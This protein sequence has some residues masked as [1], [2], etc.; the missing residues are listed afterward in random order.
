MHDAAVTGTTQVPSLPR[1]VVARDRLLRRLDEIT[2]HAVT[3]VVAPRGTGKTVL[4]A[5]WC[6]RRSGRT[7]WANLPPDAKSGVLDD[8]AAHAAEGATDLVVVLDD[9]NEPASAS[10]AVDAAQRLAAASDRVHVVLVGCC[11]PPELVPMRMAGRAWQLPEDELYL[12]AAEVAGVVAA[13]SGREVPDD[14][15]DELAGH[16]D[17][18]MA[19]AVLV[20][21]AAPRR[22]RTPSA[23]Y[24]ASTGSIDAYVTSVLLAGLPAD[25][26]DFVVATAAVDDLDPRLCGVLTA[27]EH[28]ERQLAV[29]RSIGFPIV[30][31]RTD[32]G[33]YLRPLRDSLERIAR[34]DDAAAH[35]DRLRRAAEWYR[36]W[37]RPL[38]AAGCLVRLGEWYAAERLIN[39]HLPQLLAR[40]EISRLAELVRDAPPEMLREQAVLALAGAWVLRMDGRV[41][42]SNELI[43]IYTPYYSERAS[44][45]ADL[46][47]SSTASWVADMEPLVE[48]AERAVEACD[49]LGPDAFT[50][51]KEWHGDTSTSEFRARARAAA[52]LACAYGGM[53]A[54]GERHLEPI[55]AEAAMNLPQFQLVH[56]HGVTATFH[57]LSGR[58]A[59]ALVE[60]HRATT[61]AAQSDL[62]EHRLTADAAYALGEALRLQLRHQD[63]AAA[64]ERARRLAATNGR[65]NLIATVVASQ[66]H[67]AVDAGRPDVA[68]ATIAD[69]RRDHPVR[70]PATVGGLIAAAEARSLNASGRFGEAL[71]LLDRGPVTSPVASMRVAALLGL[72]DVA[73]AQ[74]TVRQWPGGQTHDAV[75]RRAVAAAVICERTG[76]RRGAGL[77]QT[78]L[79]TADE[80]GLGQPFAEHGAAVAR[81]LRPRVVGD[82]EFARALQ[83]W[84]ADHVAADPVRF[85]TGEGLVMSHIVAGRTVRET[86]EALHISVNTVRAH[87]RAIHRKLGVD[88]RADAIRAWNERQVPPA[89]G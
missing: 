22:D 73:A 40:D 20:G 63:A 12:D 82:N 86:A 66:A 68:L 11:A 54:R 3:C 60:A 41:S 18:W 39:Q 59:D 77:L 37:N 38:D 31:G 44:M 89:G 21:L 52:Q 8:I 16:V 27:D 88:N 56:L 79:S 81:L 87:L 49:R 19:A 24:A 75:V 76:D 35:D 65:H 25:L 72:G 61:I 71:R 5:E 4:V 9:V 64:L 42:A 70:Y 43:D 48:L 51:R 26:R 2:R 69:H 83:R 28:S 58:A 53:W 30:P 62:L 84:L 50:D 6:R 7:V 47:R 15:I 78:A 33:R 10:V 13:Y 85:T 36:E 67:L 34:R 17:G 74:E 45:I 1:T 55:S 57:A 46:A 32:Q 14:G 29:L 23:L 80:Q